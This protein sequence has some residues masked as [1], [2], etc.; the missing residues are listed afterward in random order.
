MQ[1]LAKANNHKLR[2]SEPN[3]LTCAKQA[4]LLV[5]FGGRNISP[6]T[7]PLFASGMSPLQCPLV[8]LI[9]RQSVALN[10][11]CLPDAIFVPQKQPPQQ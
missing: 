10:V 1:P 6:P 8:H 9:T 7:E 2:R 11:S 3:Y 5:Q 4:N